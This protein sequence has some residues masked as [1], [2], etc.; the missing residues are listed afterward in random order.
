MK[1]VPAT[2]ATLVYRG[3]VERMWVGASVAAVC[4]KIATEIDESEACLGEHPGPD[5]LER[6]FRDEQK[7]L[8]FFRPA[9]L[10]LE[11]VEEKEIPRA[12]QKPP[13]F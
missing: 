3:S 2:I 10:H 6:W 1:T 4:A 5:D 8:E 11:T 12:T 7:T 13:M 9:L